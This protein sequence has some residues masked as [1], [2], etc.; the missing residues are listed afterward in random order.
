VPKVAVLITDRSSTTGTPA[1]VDE[2]LLAYLEGIKIYVIGTSG[3]NVNQ[4]E[5]VLISSPPHLQFHQLWTL[6]DFSLARF[7]GI[8]ILVNNELCRPEYSQ[9]YSPLSDFC[10]GRNNK[11]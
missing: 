9:F 11:K 3:F 10:S 2:A 7:S 1:A 5:L 6:Q 8:E 4:T